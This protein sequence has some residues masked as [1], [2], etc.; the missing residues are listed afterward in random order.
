[1]CSS[2][3]QPLKMFGQTWASPSTG[4]EALRKDLVWMQFFLTSLIALITTGSLSRIQTSLQMVLLWI[5]SGVTGYASGNHQ[6]LWIMVLLWASYVGKG[7]SLFLIWNWLFYILTNPD[8]CMFWVM[9]IQLFSFF[10][11]SFWGI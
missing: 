2:L 10:R 3:V 8:F 9:L 5:L 6:R 7:K 4:I 1:M 11:C